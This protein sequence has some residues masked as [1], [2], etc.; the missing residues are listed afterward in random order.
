MAILDTAIT[1]EGNVVNQRS[2][3]DFL[4][5][6]REHYEDYIQRK[7]ETSEVA[8]CDDSDFYS[9]LI[10]PKAETESRKDNPRIRLTIDN[11]EKRLK[12]ET[13]TE[14]GTKLV[15]SFLDKLSPAQ[16]IWY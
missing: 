1:T 6:L 4:K 12:L 8:I 14:A 3:E 5:A 16:G 2:R 15:L 10:Y 11:I 13:D 7:L 9:I